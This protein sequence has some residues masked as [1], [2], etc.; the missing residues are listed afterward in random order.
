MKS[1]KKITAIVMALVM[2]AFSCSI[3]SYAVE[4]KEQI[5]SIIVPGIF[6]SE[7]FYYEDGEIACNPDGEPLEIPFFMDSTEEIVKQAVPAVL[8][9]LLRMLITQNDKNDAAA[10]A[11]AETLCKILMD[12]QLSDENGKFINDVRATKYYDSFADLSEHDQQWILANLP[13]ERYIEKGGADTLY[14]FSYASLGNMIDTATELYD[15]IQFVKEDSGSDKVN[16]VPISQG[17]SIA[18]ALMQIYADKGISVAE[19]INRIVYVV[20]ALDGSVLVGEIYE[21]G[22]ID[23]DIEL[24]CNMIPSLMDEGDWTAYLIN[25]LLRIMP[26]SVLNSVLD[27]VGDTLAGKYLGYST[28]LWGL[29]P[30]GNYPAAREKY[31]MDDAHAKIREQTDWF[32]N[33]QLNRYDNILNAIDDGVEVFDIVDYNYTL[34]ELVDSWDDVN[35]DGIIHLA[36]EGM[37]T[38][39]AGVD[40]PLPD[41]YVSETN[42][43]TD[44]E[45]HDHS[46][47]NGIADAYCSLLPE[48]TFYFYG[49][50]HEETGNNNII[51]Y[52]VAELLTNPEFK[53]VHSY[54]DRFPQ[55]NVA[56]DSK[57][58]MRDIARMKA[59]DT[60]LFTT[61][62][63]AEFDAAVKAAEDAIENT[64]MSSEDYNAV[65]ENFYEV[66]NRII[67]GVQP[68]PEEESKFDFESILFKIFKFANT[69]LFKLFGGKGFSEMGCINLFK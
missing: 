17:G 33:A 66:T 42:N 1:L 8:L 69:V 30:S 10:T 45:H 67:N 65:K 34:Y 9:P 13:L 53:D 44:P 19:D 16:I 20:P 14:V 39:S 56:R 6:Q 68:E 25:I 49:Q 23:D 7:V 22:L 4:E 35:A 28:L 3:A 54:P 15:F 24:Y 64:N 57:G 52:L 58:L 5:P 18:N 47:P 51:M 36:S 63:K 61:E 38:Y 41:G 59:V 27:K 37:G 11:V 21:Y 29:V 31:L 55:F 48:T 26:N 12:K 40:K 50:D 60:S 32:Y 62:E 46:D 2:L 43:C